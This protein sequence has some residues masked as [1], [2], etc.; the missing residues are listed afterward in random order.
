MSSAKLPI[1]RAA[2]TKVIMPTASRV[3]VISRSTMRRY[4]LHHDAPAIREASS[5]SL[6]S[7]IS[8][9]LMICTPSGIPEMTPQMIR[10]AV[11]P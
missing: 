8:P 6:P 1:L 10:S 3:G 9:L 4:V 11:V 5:S 2:P 7:C